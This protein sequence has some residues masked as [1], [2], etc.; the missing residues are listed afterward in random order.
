MTQEEA[1]RKVEEYLVK[2]SLLTEPVT[3]EWENNMYSFFSV[4]G[5]E[6]GVDK[7]NGG[8]AILPY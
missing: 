7:E 4:G 5:H 2:W 8:V 3:Y 1:K 6:Y